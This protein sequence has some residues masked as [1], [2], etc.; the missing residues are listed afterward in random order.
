MISADDDIGARIKLLEQQ[1]NRQLT[2]LK[3]SVSALGESISPGH[4][5]RDA[6]KEMV[7]SPDLRAGVINTA[8]GLGAGYLGRKLVSKKSDG[9]FRKVAGTAL[10]LFL[11][12]FVAK[13]MNQFGNN[14]QVPENLYHN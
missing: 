14:G 13:K 8:V 11:T 2:G 7:A 6:V 12:R 4:F 5:V 9:V 1:Y 10:Q 3:A